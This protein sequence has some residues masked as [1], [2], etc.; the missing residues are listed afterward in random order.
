MAVLAVVIIVFN[1]I[2]MI[3]IFSS[4]GSGKFLTSTTIL[5][6]NLSTSDL[7]VGFMFLII[8]C[9]YAACKNNIGHVWDLI[10]VLESLT[11]RISIFVTSF[12]LILLTFIKLL[13]V[14]KPFYLRKIHKQL[15]IQMSLVIWIISIIMVS[16]YYGMFR[17]YKRQERFDKYEKLLFPVCSYLSMMLYLFGFI[18]I[19]CNLRLHRESMLQYIDTLKSH[20]GSENSLEMPVIVENRNINILHQESEH[21]EDGVDKNDVNDAK[22]LKSTSTDLRN[23]RIDLN[24]DGSTDRE[25]ATTG[26]KN[27][28]IDLNNDDSIDRQNASTDL[29]SSVSIVI[30][31][32]F[33]IKEKPKD[34]YLTE[35]TPRSLEYYTN[36]QQLH[37]SFDEDVKSVISKDF[38]I[39]SYKSEK[40]QC[41]DQVNMLFDTRNVVLI[42]NEV[43]VYLLFWLPISTI[44]IIH[45]AEKDKNWYNYTDME[46]YLFIVAAFKSILSPCVYFIHMRNFIRTRWCCFFNWKKQ[47]QVQDDEE[48]T[49]T[50]ASCG[51]T[52]T[53]TTII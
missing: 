16:I 2:Q 1:I 39:K 27:G 32:Q 21:L 30:E 11:Y 15:A 38:Y 4:K 31:N 45:A 35:Q 6:V 22:E 40:E 19:W 23:G 41:R 36:V 9:I 13:A 8:R 5:I 34:T 18:L 24:N 25:N 51:T 46:Q 37:K 47:Q 10:V 28:M 29:N 20:A 42:R 33:N 53:I 3:I 17:F 49:Y 50:K 12:T 52:S 44:I 26:F 14:A 7:M 43:I 48:F